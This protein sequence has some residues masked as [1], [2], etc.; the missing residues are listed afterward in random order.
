[1][2]ANTLDG[3]NPSTC[4]MIR[5]CR[6]RTKQEAGSNPATSN[7]KGGKTMSHIY[8]G[9]RSQDDAVRFYRMVTASGHQAKLIERLDALAERVPNSA[10]QNGA[11]CVIEIA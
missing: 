8:K 10:W 4:Y 3:Y 6:P 9:F 11:K 5:P 1:M 7:S 2:V